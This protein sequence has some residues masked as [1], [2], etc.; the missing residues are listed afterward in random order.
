M[1]LYYLRLLYD[2]AA[3][4]AWRTANPDVTPQGLYERLKTT[5]KGAL[6]FLGGFIMT[7]PPDQLPTFLTPKWGAFLMCASAFIQKAPNLVAAASAATDSQKAKVQELMALRAG[8]PDAVAP[9][10]PVPPK[11]V[12]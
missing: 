8:A 4:Q 10:P 6:M 1:L 12:P 3:Y 2:P 5:I 7:T 9:V 11:A